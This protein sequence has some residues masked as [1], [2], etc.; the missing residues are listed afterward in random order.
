MRSGFIGGSSGAL[1]GALNSDM[2]PDST[3]LAL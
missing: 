1:D 3:P 2:V